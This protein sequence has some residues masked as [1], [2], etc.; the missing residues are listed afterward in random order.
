MAKKSAG[1]L[2]YLKEAFLFKWNLIFFGAA[3]LGAG[4]S[5]SP[6]ILVPV[7]CGLEVA[8]LA[9][10]TALPRYQAAIDARARREELMAPKSPEDLA[11][12]KA[13][14]KQRLLDV[15]GSLTASRR[16]RFLRLRVRCVELQK[17]AAA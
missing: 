4:I 11:K 15:I 16:N 7:A 17:I 13:T 3:V 14:S 2:R 8:F 1:W 6:E 12:Q 10:L 5:P 9:S